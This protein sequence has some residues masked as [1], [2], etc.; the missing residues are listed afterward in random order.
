[1][2]LAKLRSGPGEDVR[3]YVDRGGLERD[4]VVRGDA[5]RDRGERDDCLPI[6]VRGAPDTPVRGAGSAFGW[7]ARSSLLARRAAS[8]SAVLGVGSGTTFSGVICSI[9]LPLTIAKLN[10]RAANSALTASFI[11]DLAIKRPR[12]FSNSTCST[13]T[14]QPR[15]FVSSAVSASA[16]DKPTPSF[17]ASGAHR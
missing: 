7:R 9:D 15:Y 1:M 11:F 13:A 12:K 4:G 3:P 8:S 17:T 14:T 2:T 16:T 10:S 6:R 5:E